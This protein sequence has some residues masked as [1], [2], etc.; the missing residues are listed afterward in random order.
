VILLDT[1]ALVWLATEPQRLSRAATGAIREATGSG[2]L[3]IASIS[4]WE[5]AMM[6]ML[7]R[8]RMAGTVEAAVSA[9]VEATR[10][11][12]REITPEIAAL[13]VQ[14]R[15]EFAPDPA[16]RLI[17]ATAMAEGLSLVTKDRNLRSSAALRTIW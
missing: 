10:A 2:G 7:G 16:D 1:H 17:A 5:I 8:L 3:G 13:S 14:F 6:L 12:V 11:T 15:R 4:L 9:I